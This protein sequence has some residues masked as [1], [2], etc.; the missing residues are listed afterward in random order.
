VENQW[1]CNNLTKNGSGCIGFLSFEKLTEIIEILE[2]RKKLMK[3]S[4]KY[5][6]E[7]EDN[8]SNLTIDDF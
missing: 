4:Q 3:A 7:R 1:N 5:I 2:S 6:G 8:L